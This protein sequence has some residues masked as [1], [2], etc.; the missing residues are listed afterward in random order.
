MLLLRVK[1]LESFVF[2]EIDARYSFIADFI[3]DPDLRGQGYGKKLLESA[4]AIADTRNTLQLLHV[5]EENYTAIKLYEQFGFSA[6]PEPGFPD[7]FDIE[8]KRPPHFYKN[9]SL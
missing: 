7:F 6:L 3:I 4:L 2:D 5:G 1:L 8:M 9:L